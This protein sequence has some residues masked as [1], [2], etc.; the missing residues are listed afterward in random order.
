MSL[1]RL[2]PLSAA[3]T[4]ALAGT[5]EM[6]ASVAPPLWHALKEKPLGAVLKQAPG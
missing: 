1:N 4:L 3:A 2:S 6:A 5:K